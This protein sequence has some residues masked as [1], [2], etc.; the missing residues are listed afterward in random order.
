MFNYRNHCRPCTQT[1]VYTTNTTSAQSSGLQKRIL[2]QS[3]VPSSLYIQERASLEYF[4]ESKDS[5]RHS[6]SPTL[7]E[8]VKY[9]SYN[10]FLQKKKFR[11]IKKNETKFRDPDENH[12]V[13]PTPKYGNK[14]RPRTISSYVL[15]NDECQF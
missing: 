8:S 11:I 10:R 9:G 13:D 6:V 12:L 1:L 4:H 2:N 5:D 7:N 3:R 15:K 14:W